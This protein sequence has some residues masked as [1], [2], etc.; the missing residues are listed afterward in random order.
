MYQYGIAVYSLTHVAQTLVQSGVGTPMAKIDV[1]SAY[2]I[3]PMAP[4]DRHLLD[5]Y[6]LAKSGIC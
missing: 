5:I 4:A 2:R 6:V 3:I 1:E